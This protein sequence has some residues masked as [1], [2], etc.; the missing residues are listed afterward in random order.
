MLRTSDT[1]RGRT[2]TDLKRP[3]RAAR[4]RVMALFLDQ[5]CDYA[6]KMKEDERE[7]D[8]LFN[9]CQT[10][11]A[12]AA[13]E[14]ALS[15]PEADRT[16]QPESQRKRK[17]TIFSRAQLSELER[18]FVFTPYPDITV[19]ERL[20]AL[21]LLPESKI[22][23]WFQNRRARSI[24]SGRLTRPM[25]KNPATYNSEIA[26]PHPGPNF[27]VSPAEVYQPSNP[28]DQQQMSDLNWVRQ[29]LCPWSQNLPQPTPTPA[30][31]ISP[32]LPGA[33][34]WQR[35]PSKPSGSHSVPTDQMARPVHS[36]PQNQWSECAQPST[37]P[38][39][40]GDFSGKPQCNINQGGY[41]SFPM[42]Q[43]V[44]SHAA[45]NCWQG[46]MHRQGAPIMQYPQTS[47]GD[48]SDLI[49]SASV[50]TNLAEF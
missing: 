32:D 2:W 8:F 25:K 34:P 46:S 40:S 19:R 33:F 39:S 18:A 30:P 38:T 31:S 27:T 24:K 35:Q 1:L 36:L 45:Q 42:D 16:A 43:V 5:T 7:I 41:Q 6:Q 14:H 44:P 22:Q 48:I 23:V 20:A 10:R 28:N 21:T 4:T 26:F 50:V 3:E 49:Y 12:D 11:F 47:L 9:K 37:H 13:N 17:R 29:A 15:S